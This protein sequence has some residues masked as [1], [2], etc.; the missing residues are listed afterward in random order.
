MFVGCFEVNISVIVKHFQG[1]GIIR[2]FCLPGRLVKIF[3]AWGGQKKMLGCGLLKG[4]STQ[5]DTR[6]CLSNDY[7]IH[8]FNLM[9]GCSCTWSFIFI[10]TC[11]FV[12][13]NFLLSMYKILTVFFAQ[14]HSFSLGLQK[15]RCNWLLQPSNMQAKS[16][17]SMCRGCVLSRLQG[18]GSCC[19]KHLW[20]YPL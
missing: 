17:S 2:T 11:H 15:V 12:I 7:C 10:Q 3:S 8:D 14:V 13:K 20:S 19:L 4:I 18:N 6:G 1:I 16:V 5:A 9:Y